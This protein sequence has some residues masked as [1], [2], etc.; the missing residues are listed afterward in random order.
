M[1]G[2]NFTEAESQTGVPVAILAESTARRLWPSEDPIGKTI[3]LDA[4]YEVVGVAKDAQVSF[5]GRSDNT[6]AYLPAGPKQQLDLRLL[7][8]G[9]AGSPTT[10]NVRATVAALDPELAVE[11]VNLEEN[12]KPWLTPGRIF[13]TLS[14]FLSGLALLLAAMGV[15]GLV[16]YVVSRRVREIG[17]RMALGADNRDVMALVL[18]QAMRPVVMGAL[19]G[20][21]GC[22]A[23]AWAL[24]TILPWDVSLRFLSGISPVDPVAFFGV[25]GFLLGLA[26]LA[27]YIPARRA[28]KVDPMVALRYE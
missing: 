18:R 21:A 4:D 13:S 16:S 7:I 3:R 5:L 17:I 2:R 15:Y 19:T 6:Y 27:S 28:M 24:T 1:R 22:A 20:I 8:S 9:T 10:Q 11:I 12:L 23:V 26:V 25:P 14:G